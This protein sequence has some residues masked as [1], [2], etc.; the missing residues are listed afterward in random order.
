ME[1]NKFAQGVFIKKG[2]NPKFTDVGIKIEDFIKYLK[3]L[4]PDARGFVNFSV[5]TQKADP[6][7]F[8]MWVNTWTPDKS[9]SKPA[10]DNDDSN[11]L[12]F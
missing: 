7:K 10:P 8:S 1:N 2:K 12:P 11:Q 4:K 5:G 9:K 3:T 6:S